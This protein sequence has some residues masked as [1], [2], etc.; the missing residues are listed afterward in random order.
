MNVDYLMIGYGRDGEIKQ[1]ECNS[2]DI[3]APALTFAPANTSSRQY[4]V[5]TFDVKV[6]H[7]LGNRYAVAIALE[8][9]E[10]IPASRINS[11]I[12]TSGVKPVPDEIY[13]D[14]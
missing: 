7:H 14:I 1:E 3:L 4:P 5:Q 6:I 8:E 9:G 12:E 13:G 2:G 10:V 11:L